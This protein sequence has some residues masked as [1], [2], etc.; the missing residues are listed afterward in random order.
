ML[1]TR[2]LEIQKVFDKTL[3]QAW[4]DY[5]AVEIPAKLA[6][7]KTIDKALKDFEETIGLKGGT[8]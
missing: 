4:R 6:R 8:L 3:Q 7:Q 2:E 5:W 1:T